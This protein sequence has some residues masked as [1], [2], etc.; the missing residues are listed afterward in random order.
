M[1]II[2]NKTKT[3][4]KT[5]FA[6]EG[7]LDTTNSA[8]LQDELIA[9]FDETK[10]LELDFAKI[11]YVSSTGLRVLLLGEKTAKKKEAEM[12]IINV[13][14]EVME[15]FDLTGFSDILNIV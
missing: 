9:A 8:Q 3:G 14:S 15:I 2:I 4:D 13:S 7:K 12:T 10:H 11:A 1:S 6:I 5:V